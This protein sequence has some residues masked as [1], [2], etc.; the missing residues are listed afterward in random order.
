MLH[1]AILRSPHAHARIVR[2]DAAAARR[3][4][5]VVHVLRPDDVSECERLP[6][7][8]PHASLLNAACP[9]LLPREIVSYSGQAVA[10]VVAAVTAVFT[11]AFLV[12]YFK[13]RTL[14]PFAVYCLLFGL[15]M[16]IYTQT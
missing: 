5:G 8:V 1:V 11:V 14:I 6:L 16:V 2:V 3:S 10:C 13:T 15:A 7:L 9:E 4:A 12:R